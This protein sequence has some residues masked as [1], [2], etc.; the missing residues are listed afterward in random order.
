MT[1]CTVLHVA[2]C[3]LCI[4]CT[5][6]AK[7]LEDNYINEID[8]M[9]DISNSRKV[10]LSAIAS[11]IE[12]CLL[13]TDERYLVTPSM[14]VYCSK[15][16]V[17]TIGNQTGNRDACYVFDRKTGSFVRQISSLGQG[18]GEYQQAIQAFWDGNLEQVCLWGNNQFL[19]FNLDGTLSHQ[20]NRF[21]HAMNRFV[22]CEDFYAGYIPNSLG[23]STVRIAF[24]DKSGAL[25][26]SIPNDRTWN[27]T[28]TWTV[29]SVDSWL[30]TFSKNLYFKELYCD[31]LY[32][33]KDF[34]LYP[35]YVF[36]TGGRTVPY[37][38]QGD[39]RYDFLGQMR[40]KEDIAVDRYEKYVNI[41]K[42]FEDNK[43]LYFTVDYRKKNYPAIYDKTEDRLQIMPPVSI[44]PMKD[45]TWKIP[46][47][48]FENDLDGGLPFWPQQMISDK[49]MMCV[50]TAEELLKLDVSTIT[51]EKLKNV[52]NSLNEDSNPIVAVVT[53]K[54]EN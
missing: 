53:L 48:G 46:L 23:N 26:D 24:Y 17:V 9:A 28:H 47:Y 38:M 15:E 20:M 12:Y 42:V 35:R 36:N 14:S 54:N 8:I 29:S 32:Q 40:H 41:L 39:G 25:I 31:T 30:Y 10:N 44:P 19:F 7:M 34:T 11:C 43:F 49:E 51:N 33:I 4:N 5:R 3:M 50:Y 2:L 16:Y 37:E 27:K 22:A 1:N 18:P 6:Q 45:R 52:L 21:N 13:E